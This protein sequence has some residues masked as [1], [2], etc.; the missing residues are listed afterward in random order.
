M[1]QTDVL[2]LAAALEVVM[3]MPGLAP[4]SRAGERDAQGRSRQRR[5]RDRHRSIHRHRSIQ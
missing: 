4:Q 2:V 5:N 3:A 1:R